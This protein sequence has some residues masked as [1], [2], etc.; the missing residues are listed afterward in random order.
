MKLRILLLI[1]VVIVLISANGY[2]YD[3][4]GTWNYTESNL[5]Q[6]C[7][8]PYILESGEISILQDGSTF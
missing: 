7:P 5:Y 3:A 8:V 4:T 1:T 2:A 6:N